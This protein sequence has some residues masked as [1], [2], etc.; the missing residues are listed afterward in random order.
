MKLLPIKQY[1]EENRQFMAI[2]ECQDSLHM[3]VD[4]YKKV[5]FELPW[6]CYY[7]N[8]D[9]TIVGLLRLTAKPVNGAVEIGWHYDVND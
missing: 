9:G 5:G 2:S 8:I 1:L 6:I 4:F 3:S 7:A